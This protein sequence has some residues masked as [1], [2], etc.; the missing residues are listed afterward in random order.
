MEI[1]NTLVLGNGF[2][3][4]LFKGVPSWKELFEH[5]ESD[6]RNYTILYE[7]NLLKSKKTDNEIKPEL[8]H[9]ITKTYSVENFKENIS[10]DL[11]KFGEYLSSYNVQNIITTNYDEG[12]EFILCQ[13][14][15]YKN[16]KTEGLAEE[17][18]YSIRRYK[19]FINEKNSHCIKL[20]KIHGDINKIESIILGFDQYCGS[21]SK[22]SEYI[23]GKYKSDDVDGPECDIPMIE[24]C[25]NQKFDNLSWAELFFNTNVYIVGLGMDFSEIDIWWLLNNRVR[26][27]NKVSQV[28]NK[29]I[30]LYDDKYD[31]KK[32]DIFEA[33]DAFKVERYSICSD[34]DYI[35]KIFKVMAETRFQVRED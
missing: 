24:K 29:I 20:W 22:L 12:I 15:G 25:K 6:I 8:I 19:K 18:I 27:Q 33:L 4:A 23:K 17:G 26:I 13:K 16:I 34:K 9:K 7:V 31:N 1:S 5:V 32:T 21:L 3:R 2:L 28:Q 30:Y 14:C 35:N 10:L 11:N